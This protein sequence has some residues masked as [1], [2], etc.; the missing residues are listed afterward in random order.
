MENTEKSLTKQYPTIVEVLVDAMIAAA[1]QVTA[2]TR[3]AASAQASIAAMSAEIE[4]LLT[5]QET[6]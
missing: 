5:E 1:A 4:R 6:A 3:S 2:G